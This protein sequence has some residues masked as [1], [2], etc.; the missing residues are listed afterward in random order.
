MYV[1]LEPVKE[2][3]A[4]NNFAGNIT[5]NMYEFEAGEDFGQW[6][7]KEWPGPEFTVELDPRLDTWRPA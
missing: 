2:Q 3:L 7:A 5:G 4:E 1:N 6:A